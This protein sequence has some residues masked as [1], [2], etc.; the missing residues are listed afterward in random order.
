MREI[1]DLLTYVLPFANAC[2]TQTAIKYLR[3]S[4]IRFCQETRVWREY[5]TFVT[6]GSEIITLSIP[7]ESS[8]G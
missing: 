6:D 2:P 3:E 5:D 4:A 1:Q 7:G 8:H